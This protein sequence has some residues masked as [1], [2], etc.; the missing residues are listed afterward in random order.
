MYA[1]TYDP[2]A[3]TYRF[4]R[5]GM[6]LAVQRLDARRWAAFRDGV[7]VGTGR[8]QV[9]AAECG[10]RALGTR[11]TA[12]EVL[13]QAR[14]QEATTRPAAPVEAVQMTADIRRWFHLPSAQ[15]VLG[16]D[17][18]AEWTWRPMQ[19]AFSEPPVT[20]RPYQAWALFNVA[21]LRDHGG[22]HG[23]G[24]VISAGVG[25][26]KTLIGLL[27][28]SVLGTPPGRTLCMVPAALEGQWHDDVARYHT[29]GFRVPTPTI[30][31]HETLGANTR[32]P[33]EVWNPATLVIDEASAFA[34]G[35]SNRTRR[36]L[37]WKAGALNARVFLLSATYLKASLKDVAGLTELVLG[38]LAPLPTHYPDL[39]A[40][41]SAVDA[42]ARLKRYAPGVLL[43]R[44]PPEAHTLPPLQQARAAV[45]VLM[46][47]R[48]GY[49]TVPA[50][51]VAEG[52]TS[53]PLIYSS[54]RPTVPPA[55]AKALEALEATWEHPYTGEAFSLALD[56]H[57]AAS[58]LQAGYY[59]RWDPAPPED[60]KDAKRALTQALRA[61]RALRAAGLPDTQGAWLKALRTGRHNRAPLPTH[62]DV[63]VDAS[64]NPRTVDLRAVWAAW[65]SAATRHGTSTALATH[66]PGQERSFHRVSPYLAE[67]AAAWA[68][69]APAILWTRSPEFGQWVA[70]VVGCPYYGTGEDGEGIRTERGDRPCVASVQVH[71]R[72]K[73]LQAFHRNLVVQ[74]FGSA[75]VLEQL[76]GRT[77]RQGQ[78]HAVEV[79]LLT[80]TAYADKA[81][82]AALRR[83]RFVAEIGE[84]TYR[85]WKFGGGLEFDRRALE[86]PA[87]LQELE[88]EE[89]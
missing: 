35:E 52:E 2:T 33:L 46:Q 28:A 76:A 54:V 72:G 11:A 4:L 49:L 23:K 10:A 50:N 59:T 15:D 30:T 75:D 39:R 53:A 6:E 13:A 66:F 89:P 44:T 74:P 57:R 60:W 78:T 5:G 14:A 73:N 65:Q 70:N 45:R 51:M 43:T 29:M 20:L 81:V 63:T 62:V 69:G 3:A 31:T 87:L 38:E 22:L 19:S 9:N 47:G 41:A 21:A 32:N 68:A 8:T 36:L 27:L 1:V 85:L 61:A 71:H 37:A 64:T 67:A 42:D 24:L 25:Q 84:A 83:S 79:A 88:T 56:F 7:C 48:T 17:P 80:P 86:D 58:E 18:A 12:A 77:H 34:N 55:V 82:A 26:G 40:V 16:V